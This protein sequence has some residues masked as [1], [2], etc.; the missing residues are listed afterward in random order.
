MCVGLAVDGDTTGRD[1]RVIKKSG[2]VQALKEA[3]QSTLC[4]FRPRPCMAALGP[5]HTGSSHG[6]ARVCVPSAPN[7]AWVV[8][9]ALATWGWL[10]SEHRGTDDVRLSR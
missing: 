3:I 8:P 10:V 9:G 5:L 1:I 7:R 6:P 2:K 4:A